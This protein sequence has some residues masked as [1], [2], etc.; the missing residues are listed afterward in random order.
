MAYNENSLNRIRELL[1][2]KQIVF[3]EK[4]MFSGVCIMVDDKMCC[5]THID[6]KLNEDV[7]LCRIGEDAYDKA[8]EN[9]DC[10][11]M[12]FTGKPMKGYIFVRPLGFDTKGKLS[13]WLDL[14][15]KF[16]PMALS[17]KRNRSGK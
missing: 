14:C 6:K 8:L 7:L 12:E 5:G 15:L 11:P 17:S 9:S 16:N 3:S 4:K 10:I 1:L 13:Y 2:E